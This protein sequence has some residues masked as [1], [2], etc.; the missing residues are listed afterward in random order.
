MNW[1]QSPLAFADIREAF[2][3]AIA[4]QRGI[5]IKCGTHAEAVIRRSRFNYFRKMNRAENKETYPP[6]HNLHGNSVY[7]TLILRIPSRGAEDATYLY[8]EPRTIT[9]MLIE[10]L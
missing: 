10:E 9:D 4:T 8:I 5:R 6:G 2:D 3:R 7:D 1:N